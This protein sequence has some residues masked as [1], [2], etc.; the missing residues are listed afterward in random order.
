MTSKS[1]ECVM[2]SLYREVWASS[3]RSEAKMDRVKLGK[4]RAIRPMIAE[5]MKRTGE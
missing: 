2:M 4:Q 3:E 1:E 5:R